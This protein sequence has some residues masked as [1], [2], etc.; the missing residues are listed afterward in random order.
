MSDE[1]LQEIA[2]RLIKE[3]PDITNADKLP[4]IYFVGKAG[5]GKSY[6]ANFLIKKYGFGVS[7][8]AYPV[9]MIAEKYFNMKIKDRKLLQVI[10]TDAGRDLIDQDIWVKRFIEDMNIIARTALI[11]NRPVPKFV[12]DD[13]RFPNEHVI[14][15]QLGFV[16]IYIDVSDEIRSKRLVGRDGSSQ[17]NTLNHKS[18]TLIDTFKDDLIKVDGSG[19]LEES[20]RKLN[21]LLQTLVNKEK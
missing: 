8:F 10:G 13:C 1:N 18:E 17:E 9:Y 5:A 12:S 19:S 15:S 6:S 20:F 11:L 21:A 16:G 2:E 4:N 7:K 3:I 14:L